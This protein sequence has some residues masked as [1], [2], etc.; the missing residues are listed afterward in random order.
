MLKFHRNYGLIFDAHGMPEHH[1]K[2]SGIVI[3]LRFW[4]SYQLWMKL[5]TFSKLAHSPL[6][7][8]Q[9][10]SLQSN[11][12]NLRASEKFA[13]YTYMWA[14]D[15]VH[16]D[17][18][19]RQLRVQQLQSAVH[20]FKHIRHTVKTIGCKKEHSLQHFVTHFQKSHGFLLLLNR[21]VGIGNSP[22]ISD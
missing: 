9:Q 8:I 10:Q 15:R 3:R 1:P 11:E 21:K 22:F 5:T 19:H 13:E 20:S 6:E 18:E 2:K 17:F 7:E 14:D 4:S 12:D 16:H